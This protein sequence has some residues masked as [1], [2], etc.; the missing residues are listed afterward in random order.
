MVQTEVIMAVDDKW[1][2]EDID[3]LL[4]E[5][6]K[7]RVALEETLTECIG[8]HA[9]ETAAA[10]LLAAEKLAEAQIL[11]AEKLAEINRIESELSRRASASAAKEIRG[12]I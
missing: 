10:Q 2:R 12:T 5:I 3:K 4:R 8:C 7:I 9:D 11:A 1:M 6:H